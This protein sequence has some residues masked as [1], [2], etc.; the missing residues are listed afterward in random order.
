MLIGYRY[1]GER[2]SGLPGKIVQKRDLVAAGCHDSKVVP[3]PT[4]IAPSREMRDFIL[5]S[6]YVLREGDSLVVKDPIVLADNKADGQKVLRLMKK[7]KA[8]IQ[9]IGEAPR[10]VASKADF[11]FWLGR[12]VPSKSVRM[13]NTGKPVGRP[14]KWDIR[15]LPLEDAKVLAAL[16]YSGAHVDNV[17]IP[18]FIEKG[19]RANIK[20]A[21]L[22]IMLGP[23][24]GSNKPDWLKG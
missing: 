22:W 21:N 24:D 17:V 1:I 8:N 6:E 18:A 15:D 11:D 5:N 10:P 3:L 19:A 14:R 16:Y 23:A 7:R 20:R 13:R 2:D 4:D 12:I 9:V